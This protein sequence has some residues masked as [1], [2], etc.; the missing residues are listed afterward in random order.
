MLGLVI[1][2]STRERAS[3][4]RFTRGAPAVCSLI[5]RPSTLHLAPSSRA[6]SAVD[7]GRDVVDDVL[8]QRILGGQAEPFAHGAFA[9]FGVAAAHLRQ[10]AQV[11]GGIVDLL[12]APLPMPA[13][14]G[15][16]G[17][18][19]LP[20][21]SGVPRLPCARGGF[22]GSAPMPGGAIC[23]GVAAPR[24]VPG[25]IAAIWLAYRM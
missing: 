22:S 6:A 1:T 12:C 7:V 15:R 3:G 11:G 10:A 18:E 20:A 17:A 23:T 24:L 4:S 25:A 2:V 16:A 14:A 8:F 13:G 5:S 21:S 19:A 9:P